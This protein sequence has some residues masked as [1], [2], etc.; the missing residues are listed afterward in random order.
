MDNRNDYE[1]YALV[2]L[3][4]SD[5]YENIKKYNNPEIAIRLNES[6]KSITI[7][8]NFLLD[9]SLR[10]VEDLLVNKEKDHALMQ[11][12]NEALMQ[13]VEEIKNLRNLIMSDI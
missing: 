8:Y 12:N 3:S 9:L 5:L 2:P 6:S 10:T 7:I 13:Y 4:K 11:K 1:L